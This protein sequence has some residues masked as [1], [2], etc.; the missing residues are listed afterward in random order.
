LKNIR[1]RYLGKQ[2]K[3]KNMSEKQEKWLIDTAK[4]AG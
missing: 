3:K 1:Q 4:A 2:H